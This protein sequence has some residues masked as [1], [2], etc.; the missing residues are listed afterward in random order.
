M[1]LLHKSSK[2]S[3]IS[4]FD[5]GDFKFLDITCSCERSEIHA[6]NF[7]PWVWDKIGIKLAAKH[8]IYKKLAIL[9]KK[10]LTIGKALTNK[11]Y[12]HVTGYY[13]I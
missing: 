7:S 9:R 5:N 10:R 11:K 4:N 6:T 3:T 13:I 8:V 2:V 12:K 1:V